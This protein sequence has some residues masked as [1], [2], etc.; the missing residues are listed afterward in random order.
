[1]PI[2][3]E[4]AYWPLIMTHPVLQN[5]GITF[6]LFQI[7]VVVGFFALDYT[8]MP[9]VIAYG[10]LVGLGVAAWITTVRR[11]VRRLRWQKA[12]GR[13]VR[14]PCCDKPITG[15]KPN[16]DIEPGWPIAFNPWNGAVTCHAC[17]TIYVPAPDEEPRKIMVHG[18]PV[19][20][21]QPNA[22]A[23]W[24][25]HGGGVHRATF[26][27]DGYLGWERRKHHEAAQESEG[28]T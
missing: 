28:D 22:Y 16:G 13:S 17:D 3:R 10:V 5:A 6:F 21:P 20:M 1:M 4:L 18:H 19:N 9:V 15:K 24:E 12:H 23:L 2:P 25:S 27:H 11:S 7:A 14:T 26:E 8:R